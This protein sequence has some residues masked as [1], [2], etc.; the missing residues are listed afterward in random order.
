MSESDRRAGGAPHAKKSAPSK[1]NEARIENQVI[2][3]DRVQDYLLAKL[4]A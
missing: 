2:S 3:N 4:A 1:I